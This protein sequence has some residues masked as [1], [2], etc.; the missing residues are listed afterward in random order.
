[1]LAKK[2]NTLK[3]IFDLMA[4]SHD[5]SDER[6]N[7]YKNEILSKKGELIFNEGSDDESYIKIKKLLKQIL[8][9]INDNNQKNSKKQT[10]RYTKEDS[11][12]N[13][14][15][16]EYI[17]SDGEWKILYTFYVT[18]CM[19]NNKSFKGKNYKDYGW[20]SETLN[21]SGVKPKLEKILK[22]NKNEFFVFLKDDEDDLKTSFTELDLIHPI[23]NWNK[24]RAVIGK[25]MANN[26]YETFFDKIRNCLAHGGFIFKYND[27]NEAM[28]IMEDHDS[29]N[30]TAR[31]VI[32]LTTLLNI[33]KTIN[34]NNKFVDY[35]KKNQ[36]ITS[37][38]SKNKKDEKELLSV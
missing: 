25:P 22:I 21:K 15:E 26:N 34:E 37:E 11:I 13:G 32:K 35:G 10:F 30:V 17:P 8:S 20:K 31:I 29:H 9:N 23:S 28:L 3:L 18:Y 36:E 1:M 16:D 12:L 14:F 6:L 24:E 38:V 5:I 19:S 27:S 33:A 4:L 2:D 7:N